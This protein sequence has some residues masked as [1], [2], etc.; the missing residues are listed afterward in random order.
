MNGMDEHGGCD[1]NVVTD[2][3][4]TRGLQQLGL[5][6]EVLSA[7]TVATCAGLYART[8]SWQA[9]AA[10]GLGLAAAVLCRVSRRLARH[11]H[12]G[13]AGTWLLVAS[14]AIPFLATS[15]ISG[16]TL[17][18]A[19]LALALPMGIGALV[20]P[21]CWFS[22]G[23]FPGL[24]GAFSCSF[25]DR[26]VFWIRLSTAEATS[27]SLIGTGFAALTFASLLWVLAKRPPGSGLRTRLIVSFLLVG[28]PPTAAAAWHWLPSSSST[29]A[30]YRS[31]AE[32]L[33]PPTAS[34]LA[35]MGLWLGSILFSVALAVRLAKG[36]AITSLSPL[37][38]Q[39]EVAALGSR[40]DAMRVGEGTTPTARE[41][42]L[43][44]TRELE[45]RCRNAEA[46]AEL[47]R[48]G[49]SLLNTQRLAQ[50][51]VDVVRD[52][53][54]LDYVALYTFEPG[55]QWL[56]LR[57]ESGP[58]RCDSPGQRIRVGE[59][60]V[61]QAAADAQLTI[62]A[63]REAGQSV[64]NHDNAEAVCTQVALPLRSRGRLLG[65][66]VGHTSLPVGLTLSAACPQ[67]RG[68]GKELIDVLQAMAGRV[69]LA[70]DNARLLDE[71]QA[72][73]D[74]ARRV[75]GTLSLDAWRD[76][77][78]T[79]ADLGFRSDEYGVER[80]GRIWL[81]RMAHAEEEN[82]TVLGS[83]DDGGQIGQT[84]T[85][86]IRIHGEVIG[87]LDTHKPSGEGAWT[88]EQVEL[89]EQIAEELSQAL[90][91]ARLYEETQRRGVRERQL[92]EIAIRMGGSVDLDAIM[93]TAVED[94]AKALGVPSAF[95]QLY[96]RRPPASDGSAK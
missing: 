76:V 25:V 87:V 50:A 23:L 36:L 9:F 59:G 12:V 57:A 16:S 55:K 63:R 54:S 80:A 19:G 62:A 10:L 33:S 39:E 61:G 82:T 67:P 43:Q 34:A 40:T 49:L 42:L 15:C 29:I 56:E 44:H 71:G 7:L 68:L 3:Y 69:A 66:L 58:E 45:Q 26:I 22:R 64:D 79:R 73:I 11:N 27:F 94:I 65:V 48:V 86:P 95:V 92:R 91:N 51:V 20:W 60:L 75:S 31:A 13:A 81:P 84:L 5:A 32:I 21:E 38:R 37:A 53:L 2:E 89:V 96:E 41:Q 83:R 47:S 8:Q 14:L 93:Q 4:R 30:V 70:L 72:A 52:S 85:V 77:L 24:L 78:S 88:S 6:W 35:G 90:E 28:M 17:L 1:Q 46:L 74:A 18:F